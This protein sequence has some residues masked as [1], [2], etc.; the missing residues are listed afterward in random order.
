MAHRR[1]SRKANYLFSESVQCTEDLL[2]GLR[3]DIF[4][5]KMIFTIIL[6]NTLIQISNQETREVKQFDK[7]HT[8][9]FW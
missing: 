8:A 5:L 2:G 4:A 1:Y 6:A 9:I 3:Q 7:G